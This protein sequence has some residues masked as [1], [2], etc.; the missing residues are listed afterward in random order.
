MTQR[1]PALAPNDPSLS[2][3][4]SPRSQSKHQL[5]SKK[6]TNFAH[7]N[8]HTET[9]P[10]STSFMSF[11]TLV[12][13]LNC[14]NPRTPY[15]H[16][17]RS[18]QLRSHGTPGNVRKHIPFTSLSIFPAR[19]GSSHL[20]SQGEA[21]ARIGHIP[22]HLCQLYHHPPRASQ[23]LRPPARPKE[24]KHQRP[25]DPRIPDCN[26]VTRHHVSYH[27][28]AFLNCVTVSCLCLLCLL[29]CLGLCVHENP[30]G[31]GGWSCSP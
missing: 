14:Q 15:H 29:F 19:A 6:K 17:P 30:E 7:R 28:N 8:C 20:C 13:G 5:T 2:N 25:K 23:K 11:P 24:P 12:S 4:S 3:R 9:Y 27:Q 10:R 31:V 21:N 1:D 26:T 18:S 22:F 16:P